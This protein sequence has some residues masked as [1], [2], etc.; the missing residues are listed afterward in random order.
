MRKI[1]LIALQGLGNSIINY[2]IYLGLKD[3]F[4]I[5]ILSTENGSASFYRE[6][7]NAHVVG[8]RD[9]KDIWKKSRTMTSDEVVTF[10]PNWRR[11]WLASSLIQTT[12]REYFRTTKW[13]SA[14]FLGTELPTS[15][16]RHDFENN[17]ELLKRRSLALPSI[18]S[19]RASLG[20]AP[21][22]ENYV[23]VHPTASTV[24]KYYPASVWK[25]LLVVL[26]SRYERVHLIS[27]TSAIEREFLAEISDPQDRQHCGAKFQELAQLLGGA[28]QFVGLDSSMLHFAALLD[29]PVLALWSF[30]NYRR[31]YP[32]TVN[33][34]LYVPRE[35]LTQRDFS[36]P[37][38][39]PA[40]LDRAR[41]E[42]LIAILEGKR[43][44]DQQ[45]TDQAANLI[46]LH[47]F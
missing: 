28:Q 9:V 5:T 29:V 36:Y 33:A 13:P 38:S 24:N 11:E 32:Y 8:V 27:G 42:D 18:T 7:S 12:K 1:S 22:R 2:P 39:R 34:Q 21:R 20:V 25:E 4:E 3:H 46:R 35:V 19:I 31:I 44:H 43:A 17:I 15:F 16:E 10:F 23:V 6:F 30:A 26:R 14:F 45:F 37:I 40:Y 47:L 41:S